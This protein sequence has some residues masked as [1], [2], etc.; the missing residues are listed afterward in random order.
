MTAIDIRR[1]KMN[2]PATLDMTLL[3]AG[4]IELYR[5]WNGAKESV[6]LATTSLDKES[7]KPWVLRAEHERKDTLTGPWAL[8]PLKLSHRLDQIQLTLSDPG[9]YVLRE[10]CGARLAI[11]QL[12]TVAIAL[13]RAVSAM[14]A[15]GIV[16]RDLAP[17]NI[18]FNWRAERAWLTG[19]GNAM[20]LGADHRSLALFSSTSLHYVAPELCGTINRPVDARADLYSLGCVLYELVTGSS[21]VPVDDLP[22]AVL[23]HLAMLPSPAS[24]VRRDCPKV[25]SQIIATLMAKDPNDRYSSADGLLGDLLRC[26]AAWRENSELKWFPIDHANA[27]RRLNASDRI[28]GRVGEL[29]ALRDA[30]EGV[31]AD[32]QTRC[33]ALFGASGT[34]KSTLVRHF[35]RTLDE[36]IHWFGAGKHGLVEEGTPYG[37]LAMALK[38]LLHNKLRVEGR[39]FAAWSEKVRDALGPSIGLLLSLLPELN[40]IVD[41]FPYATNGAAPADQDRLFDAICKFIECF[42]ADRRPLI[43]FLDDLQWADNDTLSV[44][45]RLLQAKDLRNLLLVLAL[46]GEGSQAPQ[47]VQTV[48]DSSSVPTTKITLGPL[49]FVDVN[50]LV[51]DILGCSLARSVPLSGLIQ[52]KTGSNPFYVIRFMSMLLDERLVWFD[53]ES[54]SWMWD[55]SKA[56]ASKYT[57]NVAELLLDKLETLPDATLNLLRCLACLGDSSPAQ[58]LAIAA[59]IEES[60]VHTLLIQAERTGL[61]RRN[62]SAYSFLHGRIRE[63]TY[64][65]L[66][67][68]RRH[69]EMHVTV[70]IRLASVRPERREVLFAAANQINLGAELIEDGDEKLRYARLNLEVAILAK[71]S[72]DYRA[73]ITY[74]QAASFLLRDVEDSNIAG[75]IEFHRAECE[76]VTADLVSAEARLERLWS[77]DID[78]V[79]RSSV[80][81]LSV[82]LYTTQGRQRVAIDIGLSYLAQLGIVVP[83]E[84]GDEDVDRDR[85][86]LIQYIDRARLDSGPRRKV[87]ASP[88]WAGAMD[89][90]GDLIL[91]ALSCN[92]ENLVDSLVFTMAL[93]T[94]DRGYCSASSYAFVHA[95]GILAFRFHDVE[96]SLFLGEKALQLSSDEGFDRLAARV[97]MCFGVLVVPWTRPIRSAQPYIKDAIMAAYDSC[98][99]TFAVYS[100]RNL[101]SNLLFAGAP[102][103]EVMRVAEEA[104]DFAR[105]AGFSL[106]VDTILAQLMV[107]STLR[108]TYAQTFAS[109]GLESN[110]SESLLHGA[111]CTSTGAFAFWVHRLQ[112]CVLFR[113]WEGALEAEGKATGLLGASLAH[114]ETADLPYYGAICRAEAFFRSAKEREREAHL[115]VLRNHYD[116]LRSLAESCP[117][118]FGDRAALAA[119]ELARVQGRNGDAQLLY[120]K[121]IELARKNDFVQNEAVVLEAAANFYSTQNLPVVAEALLRNARYAYLHWGAEGK[122]QELE[123]RML[124]IT[125]R[126]RSKPR[127]DA[128]LVHLDTRAVLTASHALSSE[129]VL[130]RLLEVLIGNVLEHAG[131]ERCAVALHRRGEYWIEAEARTSL[132]GLIY[133]IESRRL[134]EVELPLGILMTVARTRQKV[135]LDDACGSGEFARDRDV[136]QRGLRSVLCMPLLKQSE[137]VGILYVENNLISGAFTE[138]KTTLLEVF[139]SQAAISLE[140]ARLYADAVQ[141]DALRKAAEQELRNS[142]EELARVA[143]LTTMGQLVA[144]IT[145]EVSQPLASIAASAGAALRFMRRDDPNF[146]EVEDALRRIQFDSTRAHDVVRS[147]RALGKRS[148]PSFSAFGL[149][150]AIEEVLL[151]TRS[152]LE[153]HAVRLAS[154]TD[155]D[156]STVWGDRVQIQQVVLNLVVN[157]IE[158]MQEICDRERRLFIGSST[159]EGRVRVVIEDTGVGIEEGSADKIF[160]PFVT[161]KPQGMGMGLPI[162]RSIVQ[163]HAGRLTVE[164]LSPYGTR[165]EVWL[166]EPGWRPSTESGAST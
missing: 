144:S 129:I 3:R 85:A 166:P 31:L 116:Y 141:S 16:H 114:I 35:E 146:V 55:L 29:N 109:K 125:G 131:A 41:D 127:N 23:S 108:G 106:V 97:R 155:S 34:G 74:L 81:R 7:G 76:F 58:I 140:N 18:L 33:I 153:K 98:D 54:S 95:A 145:H 86:K 53:S 136:I 96:R 17:E 154:N 78:I 36:K 4:Q 2:E 158:A 115:D 68:D 135:L 130:P 120:E 132:D 56:R 49:A 47:H 20:V 22:S 123:A 37:C 143:S 75:L 92:N 119:A 88:M 25:L 107:V 87:T 150:D 151:V 24:A 163:A 126:Q 83:G 149:H 157:A 103:G 51:S 161:T 52:T 67:R 112:I 40:L 62:A 19:L 46:R 21:P 160:A 105:S 147:L 159:V 63:A 1:A 28:Y 139:A 14:H 13:A 39:E 124:Q 48:L 113:D 128:G 71:K 66:V 12:L 60:S 38:D 137:L 50:C 70:G 162:C 165:F 142:R 72:A 90:L 10:S 8:R 117:D 65:S 148:A 118:N 82:A 93:M 9:G 164:R 44:A 138:E 94:A 84:P 134:Q 110:W 133:V 30:F 43:L 5:R 77:S 45:Q 59:D 64:N 99:L 79:L 122:A 11:D 102:L 91:P 27:V 89:V 101:V 156:T 73:A 57:S 61:V 80:A 15:Q 69:K 152:Q 111:A 32:G 104:V 121:A 42:S 100:Q 6:L 26:H